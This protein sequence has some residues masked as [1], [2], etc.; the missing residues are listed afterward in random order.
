[1]LR[2]EERIMKK[3]L[4]ICA[5]MGVV[6]ILGNAAAALVD[7]SI[8]PV[9][10]TVGVGDTF[11]LELW[12]TSS[13]SGQGIKGITATIG[14]D[15]GDLQFLGYTD[16]IGGFWTDFITYPSSGQATID[17][18]M[19]IGTVPTDVQVYTLQFQALAVTD[20]TP[21]GFADA[22]VRDS[23]NADI[24]GTLSAADVTIIPEP[25]TALLLALGLAG[26]ALRRRLPA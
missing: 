20:S 10:S 17:G 19:L 15:T 3:L 9:S 26:L 22:S 12:A 8:L 16:A 2:I 6:L 11:D 1:L 21:V 24:T 4:A 7:L 23:V 5:V 18:T 14:W 25:T 13:P